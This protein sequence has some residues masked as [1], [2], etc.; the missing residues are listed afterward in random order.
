M[1]IPRPPEFLRPYETNFVEAMISCLQTAGHSS[2]EPPEV[3]CRPVLKGSLQSQAEAV[4]YLDSATVILEIDKK[5]YPCDNVI[6]SNRCF[7]A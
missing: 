3:P 5:G 6:K 7:E 2:A 1:D 4:I